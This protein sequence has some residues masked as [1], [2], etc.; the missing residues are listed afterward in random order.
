MRKLSVSVLL[1]TLAVIL[2]PTAA[3]A[4]LGL[5]NELAD[6][7]FEAG[8]AWTVTGG[9]GY[10]SDHVSYAVLGGL[11]VPSAPGGGSFAGGVYGQNIAYPGGQLSQVVNEAEFPG[12]D[13]LLDQKLVEIEFD[14]LHVNFADVPMNT[15]VY[16]DYMDDGS[17]PD[18]GAP[19]YN[20]VQVGQVTGGPNGV[21]QHADILWELDTQPQYL[22]LHFDLTYFTGT[23]VNIIDN[24]DLQGLCIPEPATLSLLALGGLALLRR[25]R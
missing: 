5:P 25:R 23:G 21:W 4:G 9:G 12:W 3:F 10:L 19:G 17:Y 22:S 16:L 13:P 11:G 8:G 2:A 15:I 7:G 18:P 14:Y 1:G 6:P 24:V 20:Y